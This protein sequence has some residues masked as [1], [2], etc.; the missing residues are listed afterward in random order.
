MKT[1]YSDN[2]FWSAVASLAYL[3][4]TTFPASCTAAA[5][6]PIGL[7]VVG[8]HGRDHSTIEFA[9]LLAA[10]LRPESNGDFQRAP[11]FE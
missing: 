3:P 4:A 1:E 6:L 10:A 2:V 7:Q 9:G 8:A 5:G 11:G